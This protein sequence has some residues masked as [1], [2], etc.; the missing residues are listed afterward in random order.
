[1]FIV[2]LGAVALLLTF[3]QNKEEKSD[4]SS[5][6]G[7]DTSVSASTESTPLVNF[8]KAQVKSIVVENQYGTL[9]FVQTSQGSEEWKISELEG[10]EQNSTLTSAAASIAATLSYL[11][12]VEEDAQNLEKYGLAQPQSTFTTS[13]ADYDK[14]VKTFLIGNESPKSGYYYVCEKDCTTVYTV[15]GTGLRYFLSGAEYFVDTTML[16]EADEIGIKD[17]CVERSDW[18]YAVKFRTATEEESVVSTQIM[19]EPVK[20][21]LNI[22]DSADVTHGLWGLEASEAVRLFPDEE[23]MAEYGLDNPYAVVTLVTDE[24]N[25]YVLK[26][27]NAV[28]AEDD[29]KNLTS[30]VSGYY[31]YMTGV[32]NKDAIFLAS[33]DSLPWATFKPEDIITTIMT[34][35]NIN[36]VDTLTVEGKE[37]TY[38]F[39][40]V[41][42]GEDSP[43]EVLINGEKVDVSLFKDLYQQVLT[44]PTNEIFYGEIENNPYLTITISLKDGG[45]DVMEFVKETD[46]RSVVFLNGEPQFRI[47]SN[48]TE[49]L[50]ENV[51]NVIGGKEVQEYV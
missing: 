3:T 20:M 40:L 50:L 51:Q 8:D 35:N 42:E 11:D 13:F 19:Y 45:Q 46:R 33:V 48:W 15:N 29:S 18:D 14:T 24:G 9:N 4:G 17:L 43:E 21:A 41:G 25:T 23:D 28:Y 30:Q 5:E 31:I 49:L 16:A 2:C 26:I 22:T 36:T 32:E 37:D 34:S 39:D 10:L 47:A 27:G 12:L 1:M 38:E 7:T 6:K 44:C